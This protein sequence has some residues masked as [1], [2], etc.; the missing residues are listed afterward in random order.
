MN[1]VAIHIEAVLLHVISNVLHQVW[2]IIQHI[3]IVP[4]M[5][6]MSVRWRCD[7]SISV[8]GCDCG[9]LFWMIFPQ[10]SQTRVIG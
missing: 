10:T 5:H 4:I 7:Q 6:E 8:G 1:Q 3:D 9:I 2:M